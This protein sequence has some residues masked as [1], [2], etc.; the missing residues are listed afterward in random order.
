MVKKSGFKWIFASLILL[1]AASGCSTEMKIINVGKAL[2]AAEDSAAFLDRMS[3]QKEVCENDAVRGFL[4]LLDGK[5]TTRSFE[6]RVKK[7]I[8]KD[9]T[10]KG[11]EYD[12]DRPIT[13][14]RLA[15]MMYQ[16]C[17]I[18]GGVVLNIAGPSQRYC[19]RE[20]QYRRLMTR[21]SESMAVTGL[22]YVGVLSRAD[23]YMR[24]EQIPGS[25]AK[26]A[27]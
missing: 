22:E 27:K 26:T 21:G 13:R 19:L 18:P 4:L 8:D 6:E 16:A 7:L 2:P 24:D 25:I 1:A 17:K 10:Y 5:D 12:A 3:S 9:V 23:I 20:L 11:W 15:Y 14:G